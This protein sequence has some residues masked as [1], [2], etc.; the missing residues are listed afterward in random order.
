MADEKENLQ[1]KAAEMM[2]K[3]LTVGVSTLFLTEDALR[4]LVSEMK[5]P[6]ELLTGLLSGAN[7]TKNEFLQ[8]LSQEIMSRVKDKIDPS[9][10]VQ[11]ILAKNEIEFS[12]KVSFKPKAGGAGHHGSDE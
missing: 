1:T 9:A 8:S 6:K 5:L 4:A 2:K 12:I 7:K 11:E 10:L 3:V